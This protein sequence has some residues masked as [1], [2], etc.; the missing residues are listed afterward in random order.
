MATFLVFLELPTARPHRSLMML[1][2]LKMQC[3]SPCTLGF[4]AARRAHTGSWHLVSRVGGNPAP[5]TKTIHPHCLH[6]QDLLKRK[7]RSPRRGI[8]PKNPPLKQDYQD[9]KLDF[10][11]KRYPAKDVKSQLECVKYFLKHIFS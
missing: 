11:P 4:A 6:T 9:R 2:Q 8:Y 5:A 1:L 3:A 10:T 7:G